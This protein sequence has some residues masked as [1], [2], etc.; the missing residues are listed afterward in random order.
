M[1]VQSPENLTYR[2]R[3]WIWL[4]YGAAIVSAIAISAVGKAPALRV[5]VLAVAVLAAGAAILFLLR[6]LRSNDEREQQINYRALTFAFAGTLIFSLAIG[7]SQ[8]VG[9]GCRFQFA[10]DFIVMP[11]YHLAAT[12]LW[13]N[14]IQLSRRQI[15]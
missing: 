11:N 7:Y 14:N 9:W 12:S 15:A 1:P 6:F 8:A 13:R 4:F 5:P 3:S 10:E 2:R